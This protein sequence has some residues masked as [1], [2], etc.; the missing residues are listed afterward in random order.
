M[1]VLYPDLCFNDVCYKGT[2]L[3]QEDKT[4]LL[5]INVCQAQV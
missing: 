2:A 4:F 3:K 5:C 1:T